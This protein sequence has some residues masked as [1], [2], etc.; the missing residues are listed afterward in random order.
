MLDI[1]IYV[2][3][4]QNKIAIA[5][6]SLLPLLISCAGTD[7]SEPPSD[8]S[9]NSAPEEAVVAE[10]PIAAQPDRTLSEPV[11]SSSQQPA[12][13]AAAPASNPVA[14]AQS[15]IPVQFQGEWNLS[16]EDCGVPGSDGRLQIEPNRINFY[17]SSGN[18]QEAIVQGDLKMTVTAEYSGEGE[19]FTRTH[20]FEL[21][22]DR[23]VL[24]DRDTNAIR[25]RC[26]N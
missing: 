3:S 25:Y 14:Q 5:C 24:T 11:A 20:S 15:E 26:S 6:L 9:T 2:R 4:K 13:T 12:P 21:S 17:E 7:V 23:S 22:S 18:V 16:T 10:E 8:T 1:L 19:T